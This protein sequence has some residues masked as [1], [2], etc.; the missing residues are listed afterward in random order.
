[1][2]PQACKAPAALPSHQHPLNCRENSNVLR[3]DK[4]AANFLEKTAGEADSESRHPE[5]AL[6]ADAHLEPL[7]IL[8]TEIDAAF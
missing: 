5:E 6:M 3:N 2:S 7:D 1:M 4:A 8:R